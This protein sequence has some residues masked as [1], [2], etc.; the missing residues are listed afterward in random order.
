MPLTS[1]CLT[2]LQYQG[3]NPFQLINIKALPGGPLIPLDA[4]NTSTTAASASSPRPPP[5]RHP[6]PAPSPGLPAIDVAHFVMTQ[7]AAVAP[8]TNPTVGGVQLTLPLMVTRPTI[9]VGDPAVPATTQVLQQQPPQAQQPASSGSSSQSG[10][11]A[12]GGVSWPPRV[13]DVGGQWG[14][15]YGVSP[16]CASPLLAVGPCSA[17]VTALLSMLSPPPVAPAPQPIASG[18]VSLA[19]SNPPSGGSNPP[20]S[21]LGPSSSALN[22]GRT[23]SL[24]LASATPAALGSVPECGLTLRSMSII[25]LAP[26][27]AGVP[28]ASLL[29]LSNF[30]TPL[31]TF[32]NLDREGFLQ[33]TTALGDP[34]GPSAE[35]AAPSQQG[36]GAEAPSLGDGNASGSGLGP[37]PFPPSFPAPATPSPPTAPS[38]PGGTW[39]AG[40]GSLFLEHVTLLVPPMELQV[41]R[42]MIRSN[43]ISG[44]GSAVMLPSLVP[45]AASLLQRQISLLPQVRRMGRE[46]REVDE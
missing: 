13:L 9:L 27:C 17:A 1:H 45:G 4:F 16:Y 36:G 21:S 31:W 42:L 3:T 34:T 12:S 38:A 35:T 2:H 14:G 44:G 43:D 40:P 8:P 37:P 41:L 25:N 7:N 11:S 23:Y 22:T 39:P 26:A 19:S 15:T 46:R 24:D 5:A 30:S 10:S 28:P 6:P 32:G 33:L 29:P 20:S 18:P